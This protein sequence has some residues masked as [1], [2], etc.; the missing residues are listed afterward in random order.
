[1]LIEKPWRGHNELT[2]L[3][4]FS[5]AWHLIH[6]QT[7]VST[8]GYLLVSHFKKRVGRGDY[9]LGRT[10]NNISRTG[11]S[12]LPP[13]SHEVWSRRL[14]TLGAVSPSG[15]REGVPAH[16]FFFFG[17]RAFQPFPPRALCFTLPVRVL[18]CVRARTIGPNISLRIFARQKLIF[19]KQNKTKQKTLC[20]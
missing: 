1:M 4:W 9:D 2:V 18:S 5:S 7:D 13:I 17:A 15:R 19:K 10:L 12:K 16:F 3:S 20:C 6:L 11:L 8:L 14:D